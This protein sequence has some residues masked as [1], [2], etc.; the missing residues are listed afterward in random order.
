MFYLQ[1]C[2]EQ[3][4]W[5]ARGWKCSNEKSLGVFN[6]NIQYDSVNSFIEGVDDK[7]M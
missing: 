7:Q 5:T 1:H 4:T 6:V 2:S 3:T